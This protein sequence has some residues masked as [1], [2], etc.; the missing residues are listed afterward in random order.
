MADTQLVVSDLA[1]TP[2]LIREEGAGKAYQ[3]VAQSSAIAIQDAVDNLRNMNTI[4]TTAIGVAM[5]QML[6]TESPEPW[7]S[8]IAEAQTASL[9]AVTNFQAIGTAA[10]NILSGFPNS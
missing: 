5:A 2:E 6:A 3:S 4:S 7:S 10:T 1:I 9:A 8:I